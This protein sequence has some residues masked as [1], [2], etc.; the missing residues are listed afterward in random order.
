MSLSRVASEAPP[1][2]KSNK[3]KTRLGRLPRV[4]VPNQLRL[5]Q[6]LRPCLSTPTLSSQSPG[7][8]SL[9]PP[10]ER[11]QR[12]TIRRVLKWARS[13]AQKP[14]QSTK[15]PSES[16][17]RPTSRRSSSGRRGCLL[18]RPLSSRS[19]SLMVSCNRKA[20]FCQRNT[21][22]VSKSRFRTS[23]ATCVVKMKISTYCRST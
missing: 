17:S 11:P 18:L 6:A 1:A 3:F 12:V 23:V 4:K 13:S 16:F 8:A 5:I 22:L 2:Y 10:L 7:R 19:T 14:T 20:A 15:A 21:G 9:R